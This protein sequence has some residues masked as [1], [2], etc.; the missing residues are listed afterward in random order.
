MITVF[1]IRENLRINNPRSKVFC[2]I[3]IIDSPAFVVKPYTWKSLAPP[4]IP[5]GFRMNFPEAV[6]PS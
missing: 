6:D 5:V 1:H 3:D 2:N 4:G